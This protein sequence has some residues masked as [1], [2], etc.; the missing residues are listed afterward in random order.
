LR[1]IRF[2]VLLVFLLVAS[3]VLIRTLGHHREPETAHER[4]ARLVGKTPATIDL[5]KLKNAGAEDLY[6]LGEE[7]LQVWHV[8]DAT[9]LFERAVAADSTRHDAWLRLVECYA[10]PT[11]DDERGLMRAAAH[12]AT[13]APSPADT[14]LVS[15]LK[16]LFVDQDYAT[17]IST[18]SALTRAKNPSADA[19]F[20][21]ALAYYRLGRLDDASKHLEPLL[22]KDATVGRVVELSIRRY[23]AAGQF[24]RAAR[25]ASELSSLYPEEP[26]PLVLLAQVELARDNAAAALESA[27]HALELDPHCVPAI[28]TRSCLYAQAGDFESARVSYE[29]LMLFDDPVLASTGHEGIAFADF[30]AG[31]F[32][33]GVD[34]MDEAIREA[35]TAG[36]HRRGLAL[37]SALVD[38]LCQLGRAD[39]AESVV[40]RWITEFGDTPVRIARARIQLAHGNVDAANDVLARLTSEKDWVLWSRRLSLDI[41]ELGA[42]TDIVE[43]KQAQALSRFQADEKE[44]AP[45]GAWAAGRRKFFIGYAAFQSGQAEA[46]TKAFAEVRTHMWGLEFPYHGDPVLF[47]QSY[48]YRAEAQLASGQRDAARES[49]AAFIRYWG[50]AAW[51]LDAIKRARQKVEALGGAAAPTQG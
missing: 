27:G 13:T 1:T 32:D 29:K 4:L 23:A 10:N 41:T 45:V 11:V 24:D 39:A 18:L 43:D 31:D 3:V 50:D 36:A 34:S 26:M 8:R 37:A 51:D 21:L 46:A 17:A 7:Y 12:A 20:Y 15:G 42:L 33:D 25:D 44:R 22:K 2:A 49:Y 40:E 47:V 16:S 35:M 30:L 48:F 6:Q 5:D 9:L 19:Q 38:A 28:I 14:V